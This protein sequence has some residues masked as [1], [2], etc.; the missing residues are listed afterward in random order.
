M[1][2]AYNIIKIISAQCN[3]QVMSNEQ[4]QEQF[5]KEIQ[6]ISKEHNIKDY[7]AFP[8]WVCTNI[9]DID[10]E[11]DVDEA[12]GIGGSNDYGIDILYIDDG[13]ETSQSVWIVQSKFS[14]TLDHSVDRE[15]ILSFRETLKYLENCPN[16]ANSD[17]QQK[18]RDYNM[19]RQ[20]NPNLKKIML[21]AVTGHLND[22]AKQLIDDESNKFSSDIEIVILDLSAV[23]SH[24]RTPRTPDIKI[25]FNGNIIKRPDSTTKKESIIG[26]VSAY[27]LIK[28]IK[29][30]KRTI[31]LENPREHL[32]MSPTNKEIMKTIADA[33]KR[34]RFWKLN[35]GITAVCDDF[36]ETAPNEFVVKNLKVV[37]G[38]QTTFALEK[39]PDPNNNIFV[40]LIIH[41]TVDDDEHLLISQTTNTQ[42]P[43]KPIDLIATANELRNLVSQCKMRFPDF[44]FERQ[45]KGFNSAPPR[46]QNRVTR[47]R[48]LEKNTT[49][50]AYYAYAIDSS[51][52]MM[53]DKDLFSLTDRTEYDKVFLERKI[54]E[55]IIP[56]IFLKTLD[57]LCRNWRRK[58]QAEDSKDGARYKTQSEI[59]SKRITK[60]FV[61]RFI[62]MTMSE[63]KNDQRKS[64]EEEIIKIFRSLEKR[65]KIPESFR[66][67]VEITCTSFMLWFD[68]RKG[69]T[70]PDKLYEKISAPGYKMDKNDIPTPYDIMYRLKK[71]GSKILQSLTDERKQRIELDDG[72]DAIKSKLLDF[73]SK[74]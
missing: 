29:P 45:T 14:S 22:Q 1:L 40:T 7:Q 71:H 30:Y 10:N 65:D 19:R 9:L 27:D 34:K 11:L 2:I 58:S 48:L 73:A 72:K 12:V 28:S 39:S 37:N 18:S 69:D 35:N 5:M 36:E 60:Y 55:L 43:I 6:D 32:S 57:E 15:E 23:L 63:I 64:V 70:W 8:R 50:R 20:E 68:S 54:E 16:D 25:R 3:D 44:Y 61:L 33:E 74:Q 66:G 42:N 21:F 53:P 56:H 49:A 46:I 41:E 38:R 47:R 24:V 67:V 4:M 13:D 17:F 26:H 52:A 59:F 31:Y 62:G 51:S